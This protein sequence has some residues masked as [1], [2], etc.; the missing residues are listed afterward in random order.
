[1]LLSAEERDD[2]AGREQFDP[3][4]DQQQHHGDDRTVDEQQNREDDHR[5]DRDILRMDC[6][7]RAACR[8]R[9]LRDR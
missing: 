8:P 1:M 3:D 6:R 2:S 5:A 7:R 9:A 4:R